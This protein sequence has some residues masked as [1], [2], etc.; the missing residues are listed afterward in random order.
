ML[1]GCLPVTFLVS[2]MLGTTELLYSTLCE[3]LLCQ[4]IYFEVDNS[5]LVKF[6][7]Y[8]IEHAVSL[9]LIFHLSILG[10]SLFLGKVNISQR[11]YTFRKMMSQLILAVTIYQEYKITIEIELT[12]A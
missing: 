12:L 3:V 7:E 2:N 1:K 5:M 4:L 11:N 8:I 10:V 6:L 9:D